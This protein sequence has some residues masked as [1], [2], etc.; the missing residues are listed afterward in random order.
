MRGAADWVLINRACFAVACALALAKSTCCAHT[1]SS[2][3]PCPSPAVESRHGVCYSALAPDWTLEALEQREALWLEAMRD[4]PRAPELLSKLNVRVVT[5]GY[6]A[7]GTGQLQRGC[8]LGPTL[9]VVAGLPVCRS[10]A[11]HE[12]AHALFAEQGNADYGHKRP[13][14]GPILTAERDCPPL[15]GA[16]LERTRQALTTWGVD[17]GNQ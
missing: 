15:S 13:E 11:M 2:G 4:H 9:I 5:D 3:A 16:W 10:A 8:T 7:C 12:A 1:Q 17:R 6:V 14:W